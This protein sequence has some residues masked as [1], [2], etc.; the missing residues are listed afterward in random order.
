MKEQRFFVGTY[1]RRTGSRGIYTLAL[2]SVTGALRLLSSAGGSPNPSFL[3]RRGDLL[4][5]A[6]EGAGC[7]N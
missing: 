4:F 7:G 1:T 2:D 3:T 5:A 6:S